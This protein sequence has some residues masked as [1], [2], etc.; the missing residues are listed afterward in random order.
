M[1]QYTLKVPGLQCCYKIMLALYTYPST[2]VGLVEAVVPYD[3]LQPYAKNT[4]I[5]TLR[6][7]AAAVETR[8]KSSC[9]GVESAD[10]LCALALAGTLIAK[11]NCMEG[12]S[13]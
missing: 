1:P 8:L 13:M 4:A 10:L 7:E 11:E 5:N 9:S 3:Q 6:L 2:C 12:G